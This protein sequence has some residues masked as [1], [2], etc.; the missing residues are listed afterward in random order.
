MHKGDG[1]TI[2]LKEVQKSIETVAGQLKTKRDIECDGSLCFQNQNEKHGTL[3][4]YSP[5]SLS[6]NKDGLIFIADYN[7]IWMLN[8]T[9]EPRKILELG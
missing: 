3:K 9:E 8:S 7:Y 1:T 2:Y 4:L 5:Y 6:I